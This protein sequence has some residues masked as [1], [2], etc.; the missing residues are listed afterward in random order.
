MRGCRAFYLFF[1][2]SSINATIQ[3]HECQNLLV[4]WHENYFEIIC[5][6]RNTL[7]FGQKRHF[8]TFPEIRLTA[9]SVIQYFHTF[10][11]L[12]DIVCILGLFEAS[13][14]FKGVVLC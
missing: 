12:C 10:N 4:I 8:R 3:E 6:A 9:K 13:V 11:I 5:L 14:T 2:T 7:G 1:A